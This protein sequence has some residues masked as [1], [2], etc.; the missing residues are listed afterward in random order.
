MRRDLAFFSVFLVIASHLLI[1]SPQAQARAFDGG[2]DDGLQMELDE[3]MRGL[4]D[5]SQLIPLKESPAVAKRTQ[6]TM[7]FNGMQVSYPTWI[8]LNRMQQKV[9]RLKKMLEALH[10]KYPLRELIQL[11]QY[12][13]LMDLFES[14]KPLLPEGQKELVNVPHPQSYIRKMLQKQSRGKGQKS[15]RAE[16]ADLDGLWSRVDQLDDM[17]DYVKSE[18][19][20]EDLEQMP[21][22]ETILG[23]RESMNQFLPLM[24]GDNQEQR[25][26]LINSRAPYKEVLD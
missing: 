14:L 17:I 11:K 13:T 21:Q 1:N 24:G 20:L 9:I 3:V 25:S 10:R 23:L 12:K 26:H 22:W 2:D 15:K 8:R 5:E 6:L 16:P 4:A 18:Y 19:S 7:D